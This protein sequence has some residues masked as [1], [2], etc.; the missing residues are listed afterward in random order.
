MNIVL[1]VFDTL[2]PE[3]LGC[4][5]GRAKTPNMDFL[6]SKGVVFLNAFTDVASTL[7]AHCSILTGLPVVKHKIRQN[8]WKLS[9]RIPLYAE[10]F[11]NSGYETAAAVSSDAL[12]SKYGLARGFDAYYEYYRSSGLLSSSLHGSLDF[13]VNVSRVPRTYLKKLFPNL[14]KLE[15]PV[16]GIM[17]RPNRTY[18]AANKNVLKWL[19]ARRNSFFL[20]VHYVDVQF[21]TGKKRYDDG[22]AVYD[23]AVGEVISKLKKEN[24]LESSLI[25]LTS[26]HG[27]YDEKRVVDTHGITAYDRDIRV[28]LILYYPAALGHKKVSFLARGMD[29]LATAADLAGMKPVSSDVGDGVSLA[30]SIL[31]NRQV[32]PEIFSQASSSVP[33]TKCVRTPEWKYIENAGKSDEL[34]NVK[35]DPEEKNNLLNSEKDKATELRMKLKDYFNVTYETQETDEYT[36]QMLRDLGYLKQD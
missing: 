36:K 11:K 35:L 1:F 20:L 34:F 24:L 23:A 10:L 12:G 18:H 26:D 13:L 2:R 14:L 16:G 30:P 22:V 27:V 33:E 8:G 25:I 28:P 21:Q 32:V 5:G 3:F 6:A 29:I 31:E 4:Y 15:H 19:S 17:G 9:E 7:P